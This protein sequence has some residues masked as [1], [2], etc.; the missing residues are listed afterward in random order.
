MK[1]PTK[2]LPGA[3][4]DEL[5]PAKRLRLQLAPNPTQPI[6]AAASADRDFNG[7]KVFV[8][9][10]GVPFASTR[11]RLWKAS[12]ERRGGSL[13]QDPR[14]AASVTHVV[15]G[16]GGIAALPPQLQPGARPTGSS[17]S[18]RS[19]PA[20][21]A[22]AH[23][24]GG[25]VGRSK[26]VPAATGATKVYV[27]HGWVEQSLAKGRLQPPANFPPPDPAANV[28]TPT[29]G[30]ASH[31]K[32]SKGSLAGSA[33]AP[34]ASEGGAGGAVFSDA[35]RYRRWLGEELWHPGCESMSLTELALQAVYS[36]ERS[37]RIGNEPVVQA[38]RQA[39]QELS[40]YERALHPDYFEE[41]Q[42]GVGKGDAMNHRALRYSRVAAV[43]RA[44]SYRLRPDLQAGDLP[45]V[46]AATAVQLNDIIETGTCAALERFRADEAILDS[47]GRRRNDSIGGA[48]RA[49]FNSLPGVGQRAAKLWWD[50]GCRS[51][52]DVELAAQP[53]GPL[54]P[55]GP[56][57]LPPEQRFSLSHRADL[58]ESTCKR[59]CWGLSAE[60]HEMLGAVRTGLETVS[61]HG[62]WRCALVGGGR[63]SSAVHDADV[64]VTHPEQPT[65]GVIL[66]LRDHFVA[67]GRLIPPEEGMCRVQEGLLPTHLD[68]LR[69]EHLHEASAAP[70]RETMDKFDHIYGVYRTLAGKLR[71]L[72]VILCPPDEWALAL[73]G[74]T[75]SRQ[76]LR[77]MRQHVKDMG[78]FLSS[79]RLMRKVGGESL[80][81]PEQAP[82]LDRSGQEH[83][84]P[85]W[86]PTRHVHTEADLFE[87]LGIPFRDPH[88]RNAP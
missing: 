63:R 30:S 76:Y 33:A 4:R 2:A 55:D 84:P 37:R 50:L 25:S 69:E 3:Q 31:S 88:E 38:L 34:G 74:W 68:R 9:T 82:P 51:F 20:A 77:F 47:R 8:P 52:E 57:P 41:G 35:E 86:G 24:S 56:S 21:A 14:E 39:G 6:S 87:L 11:A 72:D 29:A 36:E 64:L 66:L 40:K 10:S 73:V 59:A 22:A 71:R 62:G 61:G 48:T 45:F 46:G 26:A 12:V 7:V 49:L 53:G 32:E 81:V 27:N 16:E 75:G 58:L 83:W 23:A 44:C 54:G 42:Q 78:M 28:P 5:P 70:S 43:V 13:T 19:P 79:H 80:I 85:G 17:S 1:G 67:E 60:V 18:A 15:V 65:E